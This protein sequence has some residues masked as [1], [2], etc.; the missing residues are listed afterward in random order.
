MKSLAVLLAG[1][2]AAAD[3]SGT[4]GS[5]N[6]GNSYAFVR[7]GRDRGLDV[8]VWRNRTLGREESWYKPSRE[9][10]FVRAGEG[11]YVS[12]VHVSSAGEWRT[13]SYPR[14]VYRGFEWRMVR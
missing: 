5:E 11:L 6:L 4:R 3:S 9:E 14:L 1:C 8:E 13:R 10:Y 12:G 2:L 7:L